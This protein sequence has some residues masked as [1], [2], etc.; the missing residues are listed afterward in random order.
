M[1]VLIDLV[2]WQKLEL[3]SLAYV[4]KAGQVISWFELQIQSTCVEKSKYKIWCKWA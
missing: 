1:G 4:L 3:I 2:S